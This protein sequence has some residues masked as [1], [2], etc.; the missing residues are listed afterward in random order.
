[1]SAL[2]VNNKIRGLSPYPGAWTELNEPGKNPVSLKIFSATLLKESSNQQPGTT[3][4]DNKA[5]LKVNTKDQVLLVKELQL[6]GKKRM[7]TEAFL[8]GYKWEEGAFLG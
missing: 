7:K 4:C 2:A 8:R 6:A 1:Q 5:V 3:Y